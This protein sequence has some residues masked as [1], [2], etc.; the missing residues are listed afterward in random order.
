MKNIYHTLILLSMLSVSSAYSQSRVITT[1]GREYEGKI[2]HDSSD[3]L[4]IRIND[5]SEVKIAHDQV[6]IVE[7]AS[8]PEH[9]GK[10]VYP[11]FGITLGTPAGLQLVGGEYFNGFGIRA[12]AGYLGKIYG[13][14]INFVKNISKSQNFSSN[15]SVFAGYSHME[16]RT[17]MTYNGLFYSS[18]PIVDHW[19]Y[20]GLAFDLNWGGFFLEAGLSLGSGTFSNPQ[21]GLQIGYVHE[22]RF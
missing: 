16:F 13:A 4:L 2:L 15:L 3:Y 6:S 14:Q 17:T 19:T 18:V 1:G 7:S 11:L 22:Y 20:G 5:D 10:Q 9:L 21:L 12:S 8:A